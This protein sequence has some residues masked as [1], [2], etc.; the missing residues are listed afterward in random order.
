MQVQQ[1][2]VLFPSTSVKF[3][4]GHVVNFTFLD[5]IKTH[6]YYL[7]WLAAPDFSKHLAEASEVLRY[8]FFSHGFYGQQF[9]DSLGGPVTQLEWRLLF[10]VLMQAALQNGELYNY[11]NWHTMDLIKLISMLGMMSTG[12]ENPHH[13]ARIVPNMNPTTHVAEDAQPLA[14]PVAN[15]ARPITA[16]EFCY[17]PLVN[18]DASMLKDYA[19]VLAD[20][21][22]FPQRFLEQFFMAYLPLHR[23]N[24]LCQNR[25]RGAKFV[26]IQYIPTEMH[27]YCDL[28]C[29]VLPFAILRV[30]DPGPSFQ[31]EFFG[32]LEFAPTF[33]R[34]GET[35]KKLAAEFDDGAV[36]PC[37]SMDKHCPDIH[38]HCFEWFGFFFKLFEPFEPPSPGS[39]QPPPPQPPQLEPPKTP[40]SPV[41]SPQS[42]SDEY[43]APASSSCSSSSSPVDL[44]DLAVVPLL[45]QEVQLACRSLFSSL[46]AA[47]KILEAING[48]NRHHFIGYCLCLRI[49]N[50]LGKDKQLLLHFP[51]AFDTDTSFNL[52]L[53]AERLFN[54]NKEFKQHSG[55]ARIQ[56][57][58]LVWTLLYTL[59]QHG[60]RNHIMLTLLR[61]LFAYR[62]GGGANGDQFKATDI[63]DLFEMPKVV[64]DT[65]WTKTFFDR[66]LPLPAQL[67]PFHARCLE[68]VADKS[69]DKHRCDTVC[70]LQV[71]RN[72]S[73]LAVSYL[74][75][76]SVKLFNHRTQAA[77]ITEILKSTCLRYNLPMVCAASKTAFANFAGPCEALSKEFQRVKD[78]TR[79]R[80]IC[81]TTPLQ[82]INDAAAAAAAIL[83]APVPSSS[84]SSSMRSKVVA[85]ASHAC[86]TSALKTTTTTTAP[87]PP[88]KDV[89]PAV[90]APTA[91]LN[92]NRAASPNP[93]SA[94]SNKSIS[95]VLAPSPKKRKA[96]DPEQSSPTKRVRLLEEE[97][98]KAKEELVRVCVYDFY[99]YIF[100]SHLKRSM[101]RTR[102]N[103]TL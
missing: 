76:P 6:P 21:S 102:R 51:A 44:Q 69:M 53:D 24:W 65:V 25:S 28:H 83:Q 22:A 96:Q 100:Y 32:G 99:S 75:D 35:F 42:P 50:D 64:Y 59:F 3:G 56:D 19:A 27:V 70:A 85:A 84:S 5:P 2:L 77:V 101:P 26:D 66:F 39:Q 34:L 79:T 45:E 91:S 23:F 12:R 68:L 92:I 36:R 47:A 20:F 61:W 40:A 38:A 67:R 8:R 13:W 7:R 63:A 31:K 60:Y 1:Q 14:F 73:S 95:P 94:T 58:S 86:S 37:N 41:S 4:D 30:A 90:S 18:F 11:Q 71:H 33:N 62:I 17:N 52:S 103:S 97:L 43:P 48:R 54:K 55:S 82:K 98:R 80:Y 57:V 78:V 88:K 49:L 74:G 16:L 87:D 29:L 81:M 46:P 15:A 89:L 10:R 93:G 72:S 9:G